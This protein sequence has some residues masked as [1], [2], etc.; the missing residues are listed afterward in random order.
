[1]YIFI[2]ELRKGYIT[3]I[4]HYRK[5]IYRYIQITRQVIYIVGELVMIIIITV[6]GY[7][8]AILRSASIMKIIGATC[9]ENTSSSG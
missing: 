8:H 2:R 5:S 7:I 6:G 9:S 1:M 4:W 3:S